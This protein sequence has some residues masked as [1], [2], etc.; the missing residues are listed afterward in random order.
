MTLLEYLNSLSMSGKKELALQCKTTVAQLNQVA[1]GYR[2]AN[3]FLATDLNVA[4][5]KAVELDSMRP[6]IDW[7]DLYKKLESAFEQSNLKEAA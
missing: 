4:S 5:N 6:D 1:Y 3:V 2:K 7:H